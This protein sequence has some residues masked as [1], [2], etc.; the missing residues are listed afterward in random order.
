[1]AMLTVTRGYNQGTNYPLKR[2][3]TIMG[4]NADCHVVI[5]VPAVSR[6]HALIHCVNGQFFVEDLASRNKTY[7]NEEAI[8]ANIKIRLHDKDSIRICD[9]VFR[10]VEAGEKVPLPP[11][12]LRGAEE[13]AEEENSSTV[14]A[15]LNP[16][17]SSK[18]ILQA[19]P[20]EKL[21]MLLDITSELAQ[22]FDLK[23]LFPKIVDHLFKVFK[24]ADRCFVIFA[25]DDPNKFQ[26]QEVRT[27]RGDETAA[28]FSR[29]IVRTCI[30][31]KEALLSEDASS[32]VRL[33]NLSQSITDFR[34]RSVMCAPLISKSDNKA[35]GVIQLDTQDRS[36]KFTEDDLRLLSAVTGQ[37]A[38]SL[39]NARMH[40]SLVD[41]AGL[42][43][44]LKLAHQVQLSFLPKFPPKLA[45]Y[46]FATH[47]EAALE[48]GG[49]YYDFIPLPGQRIATMIGDVVGKGVSAALLMAKV[50]SDSRF[51]MLT[52]PG[53]GPA[54]T[55]LNEMMQ[56]AGMLDRFVTLE[57]AILDPARHEVTF[58]NAGHN[59]PVVFRHATSTL[60]EGFS[61]QLGGYPLGVLDGVQYEPC[62]VISLAPGDLILL[63]S[64]GVTE[65]PSAKGAEFGLDGIYAALRSG[66]MIPQEVVT[67]LVAAVK[68]HG[69]GQKQHDDLTVVCFGR[70]V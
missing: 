31:T 12:F 57:A 6:E 9:T 46:Q 15:T 5:N 51:V 28:R 55:K 45:G 35:F 13:E 26:I 8:A 4:R 37:A 66:P 7:V 11:E 20:A 22:T 53:L 61:N 23:K 42:E 24:Q 59:P 60:Q 64:D 2:D 56:E 34:I 54:I 52:E 3:K 65:A 58:A 49:D 33:K 47:Y 36:K 67:R 19:Q 30:E 41:R 63:F 69:L 25:T 18:Q 70:E 27:R 50:S 39:D 43:R 40:K 1:M 48:V 32:D 38:I 21:A 68:Q 14:E 10:F 16:A 17:S 62:S 44:D 29:T